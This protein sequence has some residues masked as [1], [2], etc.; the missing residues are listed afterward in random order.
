MDDLVMMAKKEGFDE[1]IID[2]ETKLRIENKTKK[3]SR[4]EIFNELKEVDRYFSQGF[5]HFLMIYKPISLNDLYDKLA[6]FGKIQDSQ[7]EIMFS[8]DRKLN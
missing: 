7:F 1:D 4:H 5:T 3:M 2:A 8:S 6:S